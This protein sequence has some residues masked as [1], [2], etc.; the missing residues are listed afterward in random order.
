MVPQ[1]DVAMKDIIEGFLNWRMWGRLGWQE[2]KRRYRRT[3]F[4]PFWTTLSLGIFAFTLGILW[5]DLWKQDPKTYLPFLTAGL[6]GWMLVSSIV[7]EGC[8]AFTAAEGLIKQLRFSYT[9]LTCSVVWRNVIVFMHNLVI[10]VGV[11]MYA[12]VPVTWSTLL[13][14]P[15]VILVC[16]NGVWIA[17]LLGIFCSRFRDIQQVITSILQISM[18]VTPI[19]WTPEQLGADFKKW[20]DVNLLFH[21]VDIIRSPLLG[22]PPALLSWEA[23]LASTVI[24]WGMTIFLYS[25]F[26]RRM[27]YWI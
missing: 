14:V 26:R 18:F 16:I 19:F 4:G 27:P 7:T 8:T 21:Y 2:T 25:R 23:V 6:L 1:Y 17:T 10:F 3:V 24:G 11:M 15:G 20:V 12:N 22:R 13:L 5:A 9:I